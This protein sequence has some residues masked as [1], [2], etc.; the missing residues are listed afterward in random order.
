MEMYKENGLKKIE[1][2]HPNKMKFESGHKTFDKQTISLSTLAI[3][4]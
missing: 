1:W 4:N 2:E 3:H